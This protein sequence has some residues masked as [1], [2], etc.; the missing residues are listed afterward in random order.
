LL[1][2]REIISPDREDPHKIKNVRVARCE[3]GSSIQMPLGVVELTLL[4]G[5]EA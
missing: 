4:Q 3:S 1:C 5:L 2:P